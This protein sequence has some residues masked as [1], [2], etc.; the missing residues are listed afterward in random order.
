V[1]YLPGKRLIVLAHLEWLFAYRTELYLLR[2]LAAASNRMM[3]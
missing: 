3:L 2:T 1:R